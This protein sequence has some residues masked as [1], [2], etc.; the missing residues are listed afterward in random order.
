MDWIKMRTDLY[1]HP[2]VCLMADCLMDPDGDL[3]ACVNQNCQC[4][5]AV[6]RNV[7]RNAVVG[8]LC[9]VWGVMR[10]RG[11]RD[12][13]DLVVRNC[14]VAVIDDIADLPG[15]AAAMVSVEWVRNGENVLVFPRFFAEMNSEPGGLSNAERQ[16][17]HREKRR[18]ENPVTRNV[19]SR[20][21]RNVEKRREEKSKEIPPPPFPA[22]LDTDEFHAAWA[23][24]HKHRREIR[25]PLTPTSITQQLRQLATWG[26]ARA[27]AAITHTVA[28]GWQGLR[29]PEVETGGRFGKPAQQPASEYAAERAKRLA[30]TKA[31]LDK[32][33]PEGANP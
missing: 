16:R 7:T 31:L 24:W 23:V 12:G 13:D 21:T 8:A 20:V 28:K 4:D 27:I 17:R 29:E 19:T 32:C 18:N 9:S 15:F 1:R 10:H 2:K 6:T 30:K 33:T 5:M 26:P 14:Q 11:Q 25:K 3:A 22:E